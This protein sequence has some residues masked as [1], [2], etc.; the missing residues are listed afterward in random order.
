MT[1]KQIFYFAEAS[2]I[3]PL[4]GEF[5][6]NVEVHYYETGMFDNNKIPE[7]NSLIVRPDFGHV[8]SGDWNQTKSFLIVPKNL[9]VVVRQ[10]SQKRG[11]IYFAVDQ[12]E[13]PKSTVLKLSGIYKENILVAGKIATISNE[14]FS[15]KCFKILSSA[16]KKEFTKVGM[17]YVG[18]HALEKLK[19]GWRLVTIDKSPKEYDLRI[20]AN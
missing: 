14:D 10:V 11:G 6:T 16:I 19:L 9:N 20:E 4:I 12:M 15:L 5:E 7:Y 2:D 13:N 1:S 17:F 18:K 3:K 8:D